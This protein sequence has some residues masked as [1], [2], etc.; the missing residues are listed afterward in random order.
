M[1]VKLIDFDND[2]F[3]TLKD[4][5][6]IVIADEGKYYTILWDNKKAGVVGFIPSKASDGSGFVQIII[7]P[8]FRGKGLVKLA[9]DFLAKRHNLK[10]LFA[11]IKKD[12]IASIKSHQKSGF[13]LLDDYRL[14]TL[15]A[16]GFLK[17][18]EIRLVKK[19]NY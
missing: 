13:V 11:T 17:E 1:I 18:N 19:Y 16:T 7:A 6:E 3:K 14:N 8:E 2:Y 9:E 12:N 10:Q 4:R 15:R 5:D